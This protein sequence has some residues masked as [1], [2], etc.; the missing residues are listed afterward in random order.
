MQYIDL[1][2]VYFWAQAF[3][4]GGSLIARAWLRELPDRGYGVGKAAGLLV[5]GFVF[6]LTI[7][8]GFTGNTLGTALLALAA[9]W[10]IG[11]GL[12][13]LLGETRPLREQI[14]TALPVIVTTEIIFALAFAGWAYVKAYT[15]EIIEAAGEKYMEM[16]MINAILR[17][18]SFPPNDAWLNGNPLS[19]YYF[20]YVIFAMLIR[21]SGVAPAIAFNLGGALIFALA[22]TAAFSIGYN[23]W[24]ARDERSTDARQQATRPSMRPSALASGLLAATM[25]TLMGNMGGLLGAL[26]C[27]GSLPQTAWDWLNVR[28]ISARTEA[29]VNGLPGGWFPWWWDW[30]RIV[31]DVRPDGLPA[32]IISEFPVFSFILGDSHPHVIALPFVM[33]AI[34]TALAHFLYRG[35]TRAD[36]R[37][38]LSGFALDA[39][40]IGCAGFM[41]TIDLPIVAATFVL[42]R[43][44]SRYLRNEP[45]VWPTITALATIVAAYALYLPFHV[46]LSSQVQGIVP[47]VLN[48]TRPIHFLL[49][50][51]PLALASL[52]LIPLAVRATGMP[53]RDA[54]I[55]AGKLTASALLLCAIVVVAFGATSREA[56]AL[57]GEFQ[58]GTPTIMGVP[59]EQIT[60]QL[61]AR[62]GNILT[63]LWL[64]GLVATCGAVLL[65]RPRA[66]AHTDA[67]HVAHTPAARSDRFA[68]LLTLLSA[69][70]VLAIE[71]V[72]VRDFFG[73]R[74]NSV[75]K[76][77]Y[78]AWLMFALAGGYTIVRA[79]T[80]PSLAS[81]VA[82]GA[83][84]ALV[85]A[86]LLFPLGAIPAKWAFASG[87]VP[88]PTWDGFET[89]RRANP[90]DAAMIEW[91]NRNVRG[92]PVIAEMPAGGYNYR[93]RM[94]AFTGLP[95]PIGWVGHEHQWRGEY[96]EANRRRD[97]INR[98]YSTTDLLDARDLLTR[99]GIEYVAVG[100]AERQELDG[101]RYPEEGLAKFEQLCKVAHAVGETVLYRC[102]E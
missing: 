64:A 97:D 16:M 27:A 9:T 43:V 94:S 44:L 100:A 50:F 4:V 82:G 70:V 36:Y 102:V 101:L 18:P 69:G 62:S 80:S 39:V 57:V 86:G 49:Q 83:L 55:E 56:R 5:G 68:L 58:S 32:E 24:Q 40:A 22:F 71:F 46:T 74:M 42:A 59:R 67:M 54:L 35:F 23:L 34:S 60:A 96:D 51:G 29:C 48:A 92:N 17:A 15:P 31:S 78:Q 8:L 6:W 61:V 90:N 99:Y 19:Y 98:L 66:A 41:N 87:Y 95:A 10:A 30:S 20:G 72:Y 85:G 81:K 93:G 33:L 47:N 26:R 3:G 52:A 28:E 77:W 37:L 89:V 12:N 13:T 63:A 38:S 11:I 75:F 25:L 14:R 76:F 91:I 65:Y 84:I 1:I 53:G 21:V 88:T 2:A 73:T 7:T 79:L 45:L